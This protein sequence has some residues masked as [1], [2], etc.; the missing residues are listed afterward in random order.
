MERITTKCGRTM[1]DISG[2]CLDFGKGGNY[3]IWALTALKWSYGIPLG[4]LQMTERKG[5][6]VGEFFPTPFEK[7]A[8]Q[9]GSF[10]QGSG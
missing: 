10:P 8:R 7:Y 3:A 9:I 5:Y 1:S 2:R 4:S 6:L